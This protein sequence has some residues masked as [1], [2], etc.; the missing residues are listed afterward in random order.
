M[1]KIV[2]RTMKTVSCCIY[3]HKLEEKRYPLIITVKSLQHRMMIILEVVILNSE[4]VSKYL[5]LPL[6]VLKALFQ[7]ITVV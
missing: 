4:E 2:S 7:D 5:E 6:C 3:V 1:T